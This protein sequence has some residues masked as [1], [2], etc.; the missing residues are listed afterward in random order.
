MR[1]QPAFLCALA[2]L[3]G[4]ALSDA[5]RAAQWS[6]EPQLSWLVGYN[7]NVQLAP[8][9]VQATGEAILSLDAVFKGLT[10][11]TEWDLHPHLDF[12]RYPQ[13]D[14]F[15]ANTGSLQGA[16][17][18]RT[19]RS[20]FSVNA[21]YE[22]ASTLTTEL[23]DTGIVDGNTSRNTASAALGWQRELSERQQL[24]LQVSY[25][26]VVYPNGEQFGLIGYRYPSV[27]L[28]DTLAY[29]A[30][31]S[32]SFALF[33]DDLYAPLTG[34][35]S[36]DRGARVSFTH[37]FSDRVKV[38][39][40]LGISETDVLG[41]VQHGSVW[42]VRATRTTEH[43]HF[44]LDYSQ[45]VQPSGRGYLIR[46]N[47][48]TLSLSQQ[49]K[50]SLYG[51]V[52]LLDLRNSNLASGP[53]LDVPRYS[54]ADVGLEWHVSLQVVITLAGGYAST[55]TAVT[56]QPANGWHGAINT[57]WTPVPRSTSR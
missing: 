25:A 7:S 12:Q 45:T 2:G 20:Q 1:W 33:A 47:A 52:S 4:C 11:T 32:F 23:V 55:I 44:D 22:E 15:N 26:N 37:R 18:T 49:L 54:S 19:E 24:G 42:D 53:F 56:Y 34:Y 16:F 3:A 39:A 30:R 10:E 13:H 46:R 27:T 5:A 43:G 40:T 36:S 57:V 48:A 21:G 8:S 51:T 9:N 17:T 50:G 14:G 41:N 38:S 6:C 31:T 28:S 35:D 29:S